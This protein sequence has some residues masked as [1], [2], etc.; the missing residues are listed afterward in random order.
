MLF[1]RLHKATTGV[2]SL[3]LIFVRSVDVS[4]VVNLMFVRSEYCKPYCCKVGC[5]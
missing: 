3:Y 2:T 1:K 5:S 4:G